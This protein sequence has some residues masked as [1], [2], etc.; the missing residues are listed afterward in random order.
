MPLLSGVSHEVVPVC[1]SDP[2]PRPAGKPHRLLRL[3]H[4][5]CFRAWPHGLPRV[6]RGPRGDDA[7]HL[8]VRGSSVPV[9]RVKA[10][11]HTFL[12]IS[13]F[14]GMGIFSTLLKQYGLTCG[15]IMPI[16]GE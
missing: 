11:R 9:G 16:T 1:L 14:I 13:V 6:L 7:V 2:F 4:L 5:C 10:V 3:G 8:P 15:A 12:P